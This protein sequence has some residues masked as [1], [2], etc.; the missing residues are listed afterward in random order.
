MTSPPPFHP[1]IIYREA[2]DTQDEASADSSDDDMSDD[3]PAFDPRMD[4]GG[5]DF[6]EHCYCSLNMCNKAHQLLPQPHAL[7]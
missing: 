7:R 1:L 4:Q 2:G 6:G 5:D 3:D